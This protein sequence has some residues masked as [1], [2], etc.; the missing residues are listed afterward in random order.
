MRVFKGLD[1]LPKFN[2]AVATMGS[3]DGIHCGHR[4]LLRRVINRAEEIA[5]ESIVITFDPHPRYV[6]GTGDRMQL[7]S[8]LEEKLWLL[9][10]TGINN[11]IIIPFTKEFSQTSPQEFI[12]KDIARIGIN[13][14]VVGYNHRFGH[15]KE[16]DYDFLEQRGTFNVLMVEQQQMANSKVSS[17][18]IRQ[19]LSRGRVD[20]AAKLLSHPYIIMGEIASDGTIKSIDQQKLLPAAGV[21]DATIE[22]KGV[23]LTINDERTIKVVPADFRG[24]V[25]IEIE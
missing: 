9:E 8:T 2:N 4:E 24:K 3:F 23:E 13:T 20:K 19:A 25:I 11:V 16:G 1:N 18:I 10:K 14:L 6:L 7:L 12:E 21:Y 22:G 15:K 5:G 17:T